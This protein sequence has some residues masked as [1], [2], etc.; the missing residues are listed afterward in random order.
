MLKAPPPLQGTTK[1]FVGGC[2]KENLTSEELTE[3]M[4]QFGPVQE[5]WVSN[6]GFGFVTFADINGCN[7]ALIHGFNA[8]HQ[9][10]GCKLDVKWP[11]V[12]NKT[13]YGAGQ[14]PRFNNQYNQYNQYRQPYQQPQGGYY[15]GQQQ[16]GQQQPQFAYQYQM[17]PPL[18]QQAYGY[19]Q[20]QAGAYAGQ[21]QQ[22]AAP[23]AALPQ[24]PAAAAAQQAQW[25]AQQPLQWLCPRP[26]AQ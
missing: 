20:A 14:R 3:Y 2:P 6:K 5:S 4:T 22:P 26:L 11:R 21:T 8:E 23:A 24:Q 19:G 18:P 7:K 16:Y 12:K 15:A 25:Q 10:K 1:L 17:Q 13:M 9:L